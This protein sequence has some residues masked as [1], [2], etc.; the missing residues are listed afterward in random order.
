MSGMVR[1][2][3]LESNMVQWV[4][5]LSGMVRRVVPMSGMAPCVVIGG[6]AR[7]RMGPRVVGR[8]V[9]QAAGRVDRHGGRTH[10]PANR[11]RRSHEGRQQGLVPTTRFQESGTFR[12]LRANM[13]WMSVPTPWTNR[14]QPT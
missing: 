3:L 13:S 6:G 11:A 5:L 9:V 4:V 10:C 12:P 2:V 14:C 8:S 1:C 7:R